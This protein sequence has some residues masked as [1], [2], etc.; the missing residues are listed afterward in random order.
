MSKQCLIEEWISLWTKGL[1]FLPIS[2][3]FNRALLREELENFGSKSRLK[4]FSCNDERQFNINPFKQKSKFI[5][6]KK[7]CSYWILF[8]QLEVEILF[9]D[10][11]ISY[12]SFTNGEGNA[13]Y[14]WRDDTSIIIKKTNKGSGVVI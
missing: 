4:W 8:N 6:R 13:S 7:W 2:K 5:P 11:K 12:S 14:S 3:Q 9:L 10:K 1:K